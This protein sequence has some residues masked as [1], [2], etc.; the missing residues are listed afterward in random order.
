MHF[1]HQIDSDISLALPHPSMA[2]ELFEIIDKNREHLATYLPWAITT[3]EI[4]DTANFIL[5]SLK[6]YSEQKS[7][8]LLII[9]KG[10]V[11]GGIAFIHLS[12]EHKNA[13]IGYWLA[14]E[15]TH[16]GIMTKAVRALF[17]YGFRELGLHRIVICCDTENI[18]SQNV[19]K[20]LGMK[21]DGVLRGNSFENGKFCDTIVYSILKTEW[22]NNK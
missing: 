12:M 14:E 6:D 4:K 20:R 13:E 10:R 9:Y 1:S 11:A 8:Q 16:K 22:E 7:I 2:P 17:D 15:Y 5:K 3:L 18:P 19:T 21:Q